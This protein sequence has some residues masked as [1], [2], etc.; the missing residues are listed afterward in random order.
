MEHPLAK[1]EYV[2]FALLG[3]IIQK[4][5]LARHPLWSYKHIRRRFSRSAHNLARWASVSSFAGEVNIRNLYPSI[6]CNDGDSYV[7]PDSDINTND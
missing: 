7:N 6:F 1:A 5:I 3:L 2:L 4:S